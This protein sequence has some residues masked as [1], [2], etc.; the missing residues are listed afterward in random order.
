MLYALL[1]ILKHG[2]FSTG[3]QV[4]STTLL[5]PIPAVEEPGVGS[6]LGSQ[7]GAQSLPESCLYTK[8]G[9]P[10]PGFLEA[11]EAPFDTWQKNKRIA[12]EDSDASRES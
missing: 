10:K 7:D 11:S 1:Y 5:P 2:L 9:V 3:S 8:P 12:R 6:E 4:S